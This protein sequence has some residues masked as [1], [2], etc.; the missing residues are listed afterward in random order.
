VIVVLFYFLINAIN[1]TLF[2]TIMKFTTLASNAFDD[3]IVKLVLGMVVT[4]SMPSFAV[5]SIGVR[6][7]KSFAP[8]LALATVTVP[9]TN[10]ALPK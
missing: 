3:L 7:I 6:N 8:M 10:V 9:A 1:Y 2:I 4:D 5:E